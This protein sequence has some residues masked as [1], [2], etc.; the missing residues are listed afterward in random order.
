M[1]LLKFFGHSALLL[2]VLSPVTL[3]VSAEPLQT[4]K[5]FYFDEDTDTARPVT[6]VAD[7]QGEALAQALVRERERARGRK[8]IEASGQLAHLAMQEGRT[9]LGQ[10]LYQQ[11]IASTEDSGPLAR[12]LRWNYG[13]DLYRS[14]QL[15]PALAQWSNLT[16]RFGDPA[17]APPTLALVLWQLDRKSEALQWYA[18]AVRTE[19]LKW[20]SAA[21]YPALLPE[22]SEKDRNILAQVLAAWQANPPTWP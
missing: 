7:L 15:E 21:N 16:N 11:A 18:A 12:A 10:Q 8:A 17:W 1:S 4:P 14:G 5:E 22:W 19:P 9:E 20:N 3:T 6:V 13:W 2:L